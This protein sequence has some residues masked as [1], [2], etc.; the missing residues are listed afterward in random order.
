LIGL[1][2]LVDHLVVAAR[3]L[4][5]GAA[6]LESRLGVALAPGGKHAL[7]G[8]HNRLLSLGEGRYIEVI[9]VDPEAPPPGRPRWF[10]LDSAPMQ[11]RLARSPALIHWAVRSDDIAA[12]IAATASGNAQILA[13]TRSGL[14]W[15][16]GVPASGRL[17]QSGIAPTVLEWEGGHPS[18]RLAESGCR[19][20]Q[21]ILR[22][23]QARETLAA[24][25]RAGLPPTE[26]VE[27]Q[28]TG[29]GLQARIRTPRGIVE[30]GP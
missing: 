27:A 19:L 5:D 16:I 24:L 2:I 6:W 12:A 26:P 25:H 4:D 1:N 15:R 30:L 22:H 23:P 8:T 21:L 14:H 10:D 11:V 29:R 7:M 3:N 13:M 20:E 9:A 18:E 28:P 17:A